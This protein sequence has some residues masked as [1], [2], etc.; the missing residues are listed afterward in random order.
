ME[1]KIRETKGYSQT[2]KIYLEKYINFSENSK[3]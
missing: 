2:F 3:I 1:K